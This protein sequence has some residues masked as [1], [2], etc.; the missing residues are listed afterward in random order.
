MRVTSGGLFPSRQ[1]AWQAGDLRNVLSEC[2]GDRGHRDTGHSCYPSS[3]VFN[4]KECNSCLRVVKSS[5]GDSLTSS[6]PAQDLER[7]AST[8]TGIAKGALR[9]SCCLG[10]T[11]QPRVLPVLW[12]CGYWQWWVPTGTTKG[13]LVR[14]PRFEFSMS[15]KAQR[16][17]DRESAD[18]KGERTYAQNRS[19][20]I[21]WSA[22]LG[23][24]PGTGRFAK[25]QGELLRE[26]P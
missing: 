13:E 26:T 8:G 23:W 24:Y 19:I 4:R 1:A 15:Q 10:V 22:C 20:F 14:E 11:A 17:A 5:M 21:L 3:K 9:E 6:W 25:T 2:W 7:W 16:R 12:Q 18:H